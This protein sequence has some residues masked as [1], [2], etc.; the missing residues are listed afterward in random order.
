MGRKLGSVAPVNPRK[1]AG[2]I[3]GDLQVHW[4]YLPGS[5]REE[6]IT[7]VAAPIVKGLREGEITAE[8]E[9]VRDGGVLIRRFAAYLDPDAP[10]ADPEAVRALSEYLARVDA[11]LHAIEQCGAENG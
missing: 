10:N 5:L 8:A 7:V 9:G 11:L 1:I 3:I 2:E 6:L 4:G